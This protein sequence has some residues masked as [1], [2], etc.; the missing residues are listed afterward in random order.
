PRRQ[1]AGGGLAH[2]DPGQARHRRAAPAPGRRVPRAHR[3]RREAGQRRL[4]RLDPARLLRRERRPAHPR[5]PK[6]PG[7]GRFARLLGGDHRAA[8]AAAGPAVR[9]PPDH[10]A[11]RVGQEHDALRRAHD[12]LPPGDPHPDRG[13]S[14]RVRVRAVQPVRGQRADRQHLRPLPACVPP[15]RPGS[16]HGRRDPRRGDRGDG[17]PRRAD[18]APPAQHPAHQRR[19]LHRHA[20]ARHERGPQPAR[21]VAPRRPLAAPDPG[22]LPRVPRGVRAVAR[23]APGVLPG[24]PGGDG[25]L[26]RPGVRPLQLLRLQGPEQRRRAVGAERR[27]RDR[28]QQVGAV[29]ADSPE[30]QPHHHLDGARRDGP[31]ERGKD[32]PRGVDPDAAGS[33]PRASRIRPEVRASGAAG[34]PPDTLERGPATR[35]GGPARRR[36]RCP[37]G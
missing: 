22:D 2:Q 33:R 4:P 37:P 6:R 30:R 35:R 16:D 32:E 17:V 29:R 25:L 14:D 9:H 28:D 1:R 11:D 8:A 15:A 34:A 19:G 18:R 23:P 7:V 10:R 26:P 12:G 27:G 36:G 21:V 3:A 13:G 24:P 5:S 20:P 31:A